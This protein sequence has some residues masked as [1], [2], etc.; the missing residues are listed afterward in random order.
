[1]RFSIRTLLLIVALA[2]A[3]LATHRAYQHWYTQ[4]Y[5]L[6]ALDSLLSTRVNN[7]DTF[8]AVSANFEKAVRMDL[9]TQDNQQNVLY[10]WNHRGWEILP[11]DEIWH[12]EY[13]QGHGVWL[14]FRDGRVVNFQRRD[15]ADPDKNAQVN[16][17]P[18]PPLLLRKGI[19]PLCSVVF[20]LG[21]CV[22]VLVDR[23]ER[24]RH[25]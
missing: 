3:C 16:R 10:L 12:F 24:G 22:L 9:M 17:A 6:H 7:G 25:W 18:I 5:P 11:D 1:M 15:F 2:A 20:V 19:W 13:A 21:T 8:E 14:Q 23:K 4:N